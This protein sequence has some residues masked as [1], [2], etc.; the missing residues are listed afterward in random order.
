MLVRV[1]D[2]SWGCQRNGAP[3]RWSIHT[4]LHFGLIA[5]FQNRAGFHGVACD[6]IT[7]QGRWFARRAL[8][9]WQSLPLWQ[10]TLVRLTGWARRCAPRGDTPGPCPGPKPYPLDLTIGYK[11]MAC[12]G[13]VCHRTCR[14]Q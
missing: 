13:Q 4:L 11:A 5:P 1:R 14:Y 8:D 2:A 12:R 7:D 9:F 6:C 3:L 10:R